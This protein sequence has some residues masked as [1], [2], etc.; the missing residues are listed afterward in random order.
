[1]DLLSKLKNQKKTLGD[2]VDNILDLKS[3]DQ[4]WV[5]NSL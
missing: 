4:I 3:D 5:V 1:M 2:I